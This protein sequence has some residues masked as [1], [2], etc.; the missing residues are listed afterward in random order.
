ML[1]NQVTLSNPMMH[2]SDSLLLM[3]LLAL[4]CLPAPIYIVLYRPR[5]RP[6]GSPASVGLCA[7]TPW[8]AFRTYK[9][10]VVVV[11]VVEGA[12]SG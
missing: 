2:Q 3:C 10:L 12:M 5:P 9:V 4:P 6:W 8:V 11:A 7:C 1:I